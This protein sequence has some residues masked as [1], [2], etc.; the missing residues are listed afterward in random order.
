MI[1]TSYFLFLL[2]FFCFG[3]NNTQMKLESIS[4]VKV[5]LLGSWLAYEQPV[6]DKILI[7]AEI[8]YEFGI[9][10]NFLSNGTQFLAT[11]TLSIEPRYYYNLE[12]RAA[13]GKNNSL[14]AGGYLAIEIQA[15]PDWGTYS[16]DSSISDVSIRKSALILPKIGLKRALGKYVTFEFAGGLGYQINMGTD[17]TPAIGL[18]LKFGFLPFKL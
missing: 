15:A 2:P 6:T 11:S 9:Y 1:K 14:N 18:D 4:T 12:K 16:T 13:A 8:G 5:G 17:N 10:R 3:Q 7:N